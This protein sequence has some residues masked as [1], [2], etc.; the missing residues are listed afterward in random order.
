[1]NKKS[2]SKSWIALTAGIAAGWLIMYLIVTRWS[3]LKTLIKG[4]IAQ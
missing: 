4:L 3:E 1:M 2:E